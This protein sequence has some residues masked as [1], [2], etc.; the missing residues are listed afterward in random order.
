MKIKEALSSDDLAVLHSVI[1]E[2]HDTDEY[3]PSDW[4]K[5]EDQLV[6]I[7]L[8]SGR[9]ENDEL[10]KIGIQAEHLIDVLPDL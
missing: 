7:M 9:D 5:L 10:N 6:N 1:P 2:I 4:D 3:G 8:N